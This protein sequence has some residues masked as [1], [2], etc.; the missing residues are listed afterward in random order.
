MQVLYNTV[1]HTHT[2]TLKFSAYRLLYLSRSLWILSLHVFIYTY[3]IHTREE[4]GSTLHIYTYEWVGDREGGKRVWVYPG[5]PGIIVSN[6]SV[7]LRPNEIDVERFEISSSQILI[8]THS[9]NTRCH[10]KR[11]CVIAYKASS[12][13]ARQFMGGVPWPDSSAQIR[14]C[15]MNTTSHN[16]VSGGNEH[17]V[18]SCKVM[19]VRS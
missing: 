6:L 18:S 13:P 7:A 11:E 14:Q 16:C 9:T 1:T 19:T 4:G 5:T 10:T 12:C 3:I 17:G 2:H 8:L 15:T